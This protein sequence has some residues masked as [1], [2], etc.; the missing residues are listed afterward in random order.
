MKCKFDFIWYGIW[1]QTYFLFT[2]W[3]IYCCSPIHPLLVLQHLTQNLL[4]PGDVW[5]S[6]AL[7]LSLTHIRL[8]EWCPDQDLNSWSS[9]SRIWQLPLLSLCQSARPF[10]K[11]ETQRGG[12]ERGASAMGD[13]TR[14]KP[15]PEWKGD[16]NEDIMPKIGIKVEVK[17]ILNM[18]RTYKMKKE[19]KKL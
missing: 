3:I 1:I 4:I 17:D 2:S 14:P 13:S 8:L 10:Q 15:L 12:G 9:V 18:A 19:I 5:A 6:M 11:E 16:W 7:G